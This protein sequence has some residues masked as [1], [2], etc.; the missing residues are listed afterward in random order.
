MAAEVLYWTGAISSVWALAGNWDDVDGDTAVQYPGQNQAGDTPIFDSR[1]SVSVGGFKTVLGNDFANMTIDGFTGS[2]GSV[3]LPIYLDVGTTNGVLTWRGSGASAWILGFFTT[4]NVFQTGTGD[5]AL[6][7][8][9]GGSNAFVAVN[10]RC[11][12]VILDDSTIG[13]TATG[14][15]TVLVSQAQ[16]STVPIVT[17]KCPITGSSATTGVVLKQGTVYWNKGTIAKLNM[18]AGT[19]SCARDT[20]A[21]I[22]TNGDV[23]GG[24]CDLACGVAGNITLTI[25]IKKYGGKV[26]VDDG[27]TIQTAA[28]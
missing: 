20:T 23:N 3:D 7:L 24:I 6:H 15:A 26:L 10:I 22:L 13:I 17:T 25:P 1:S 12:T 11:G 5:D 9:S 27:V 2:L 21:R 4:V 19:F 14:A 16:N 8:N 28:I 18:Q